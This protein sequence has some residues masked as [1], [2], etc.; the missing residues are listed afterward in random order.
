MH[1]QC[2]LSIY[3]IKSIIHNTKE[4]KIRVDRQMHLQKLTTEKH[5]E[6]LHVKFKNKKF[7]PGHFGT[8]VFHIFKYT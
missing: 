7:S 6:Y 4:T 3:D 8:N 2:T 5:Y 1:L